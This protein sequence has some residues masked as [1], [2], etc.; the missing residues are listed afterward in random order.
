MKSKFKRIILLV[1]AALIFITG[2]LLVPCNL[3]YGYGVASNILSVE[4]KPIWILINKNTVI[5]Q[6]Y[7]RYDINI[8]RAG[9][10]FIVISVISLALYLFAYL[11]EKENNKD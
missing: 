9:Y 1:Y 10:T 6:A 3:L 4:Y 7:A 2:I 11:I 8:T 5:N